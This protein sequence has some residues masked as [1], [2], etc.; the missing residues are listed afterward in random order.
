[1]QLWLIHL[2]VVILW[3]HATAANH[4]GSGIESRTVLD[5]INNTC[6]FLATSWKIGRCHMD[7]LYA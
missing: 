5:A 7:P 6:A 2:G 1:M 4:P 3:T